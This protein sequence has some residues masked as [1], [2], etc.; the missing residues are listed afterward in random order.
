MD[1]RIFDFCNMETENPHKNL[2]NCEN[3]GKID[4]QVLFLEEVPM[5]EAAILELNRYL[6]LNLQVK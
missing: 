4:F 5:V 6:S 3:D 1:L 2:H